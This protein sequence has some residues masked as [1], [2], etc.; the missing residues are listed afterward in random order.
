MVD[1]NIIKAYAAGVHSFYQR[2]KNVHLPRSREL[3]ISYTVA[4]C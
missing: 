3:L 4:V 1:E 2:A